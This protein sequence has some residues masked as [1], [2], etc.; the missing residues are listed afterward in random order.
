MSLQNFFKIFLRPCQ[1]KFSHKNW[2]KYK[3]YTRNWNENT[4]W[5]TENVEKIKIGTTVGLTNANDYGPA[6]SPGVLNFAYKK[7]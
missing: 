1:N 7:L 6:T 3:M 5:I 4:F 2:S